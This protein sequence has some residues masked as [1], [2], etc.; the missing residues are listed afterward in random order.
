MG[1]YPF[2]RT[3]SGDTSHRRVGTLKCGTARL[4][5]AAMT[6]LVWDPYVRDCPTREVLDR[7]GDRWS[8]LIIGFLTA[9]PQRFSELGR[10]VEGI[11]QKMLTQTLRGL[12]RDG[13]IT[14]TV[15]PVVPPHVE[16]EL[17]DLG[18]TLREPLAALDSWARG[19]VSSIL[20]AR[21]GYDAAASAG[22][23]HA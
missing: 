23:S 17:T 16:Y 22:Q 9:G 4:D 20:A 5:T 10:R 2:Q 14:R 15:F 19:H 3:V 7:I 21:Q 13:L 6:E 11:S 12:E 18:R 8:V 1:C